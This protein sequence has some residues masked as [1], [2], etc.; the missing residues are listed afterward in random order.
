MEKLV[1]LKLV[2]YRYELR[3]CTSTKNTCFCYW[4]AILYYYYYKGL[5][6]L[7]KGS[8]REIN[9]FLDCLF[10]CVTKSGFL[11]KDS[12]LKSCDRVTYSA[13][14]LKIF[15]ITQ[16]M[17][18]VGAQKAQLSVSWNTF[19]SLNTG[20]ISKSVVYISHLDTEMWE[21]SFEARWEAPGRRHLGNFW[22]LLIPG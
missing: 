12:C 18:C 21:N 16:R 3:Q 5:T 4:K 2:Q 6:I 15:L 17:C 7:Y 10:L 14:T 11:F 9:V 20:P 13:V 22:L 8:Y 1:C 19:L